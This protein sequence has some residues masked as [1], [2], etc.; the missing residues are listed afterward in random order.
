MLT[1]TCRV[2]WLIEIAGYESQAKEPF[3]FISRIQPRFQTTC[4]AG[5]SKRDDD[6]GIILGVYNYC[7]IAGR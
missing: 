3:L 6:N 4:K 5:H 2:E 7:E 1:E